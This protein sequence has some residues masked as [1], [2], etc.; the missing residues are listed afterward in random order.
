MGRFLRGRSYSHEVSTRVLDAAPPHSRSRPPSIRTRLGDS[1][2]DRF[3]G[4]ATGDAAGA[5]AAVGIIFLFN[6]FVFVLPG[7]VVA[8]IGGLLTRK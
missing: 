1:T 3:K 8:G 2:T 5:A 7:L 4:F 6:M